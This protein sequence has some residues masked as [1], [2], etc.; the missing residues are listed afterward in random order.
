MGSGGALIGGCWP[1]E[2]GGGLTRTR[3][4]CDWLGVHTRLSPVGPQLEMR[5]NMR[6]AG[7][8]LSSPGYSGPLVTGVIVWL[9]GSLIKIAV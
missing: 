8:Y 7:G 5:T 2:A 4:L 9:P 3:V 1:G 6:K